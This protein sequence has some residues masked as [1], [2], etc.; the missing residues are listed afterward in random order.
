MAQIFKKCKICNNI[1]TIYTNSKIT[2]CKSCKSEFNTNDLLNS[3][4]VKFF[5][6]L[7][8]E[9]NELSLKY[10]A[11]IMQG[12]DQILNGQFLDAEKT[13]KQAI[14]LDESRY[15]AFYGITRAK[16]Q[17]FQIIPTD[18]D[19]L[20]YAKIAINKADDDIDPKINANLAKLNILKTKSQN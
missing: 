10:N 7:D 9:K 3:D 11:L 12:N 4:D 18:N 20:E 16:T 19:Y 13:Y 8:S 15:E 17:D 14:S 2:I 5:E 6:S 1:L